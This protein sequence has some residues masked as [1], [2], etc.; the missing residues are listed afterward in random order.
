MHAILVEA[1]CTGSLC[2]IKVH[3]SC[4]WRLYE[5]FVHFASYMQMEV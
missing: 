4:M 3:R 2:V 1:V 5:I